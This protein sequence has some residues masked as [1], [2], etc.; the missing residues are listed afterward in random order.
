MSSSKWVLY[1]NRPITEQELKAIEELR[2]IEGQEVRLVYIYDS[3]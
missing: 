2:R 1:Y 3:N